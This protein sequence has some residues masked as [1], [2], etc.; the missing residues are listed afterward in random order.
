VTCTQANDENLQSLREALNISADQSL[1]QI[2]REA[3]GRSERHTTSVQRML[4]E[5]QSDEW[6]V[7][8]PQILR[9][10]SIAIGRSLSSG[11]T[12]DDYNWDSLD[13]NNNRRLTLL[14]YLTRLPAGERS[15]VL[16]QAIDELS[17]MQNAALAVCSCY[18]LKS[19]EVEKLL[20]LSASTTAAQDSRVLACYALLNQRPA[21]ARDVLR[22]LLSECVQ[23][24]AQRKPDVN[25]RAS[26]QAFYII[27]DDATWHRLITLLLLADSYNVPGDS[28]TLQRLQ[29]LDIPRDVLL[30]Y[31]VMTRVDPKGNTAVSMAINGMR[32]TSIFWQ[33][34]AVLPYKW[35]GRLEAMRLL[36]EANP[37]V[38]ARHS[39]QLLAAIDEVNNETRWADPLEQALMWRCLRRIM[40]RLSSEKQTELR[41]AVGKIPEHLPHQLDRPVPASLAELAKELWLG[42]TESALHLLELIF[43]QV[44]DDADHGHEA[45][46]AVAMC[47]EAAVVPHLSATDHQILTGL[48]G[49]PPRTD[50][51]YRLNRTLT[52]ASPKAATDLKAV[53]QWLLGS[54]LANNSLVKR[55]F[56][57]F[58]ADVDTKGGPVAGSI[59]TGMCFFDLT[60]HRRYP[61][62]YHVIENAAVG[63]IGTVK[64]GGEAFFPE[65]PLVLAENDGSNAWFR[66]QDNK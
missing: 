47:M 60:S 5:D 4:L 34:P 57:S 1:Q 40:P 38:I 28:E 43:D 17:P 20:R 13:R 23:Q 12:A 46:A 62:V 41:S 64:P 59:R 2:F 19:S 54:E 11:S 3:A 15:F 35:S 14:L 50:Y 61:A 9:Q 8:N 48:S 21:S 27:P 45:M 58:R 10:H 63:G 66:S 30:P 56:G 52:L 44:K 16:E 55:L 49:V 29:S 53:E 6:Y 24:L 25:S 7:R 18:P 51:L 36:T 42:D 26:V 32:K 37:A 33:G 65:W 39:D 31:R 22:S